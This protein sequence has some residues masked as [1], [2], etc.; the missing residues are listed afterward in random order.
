MATVC[1]DHH[2]LGISRPPYGHASSA[3]KCQRLNEVCPNN[4][5]RRAGNWASTILPVL[6]Q[7]VG[8]CFGFFLSKFALFVRH[9]F[10][11]HKCP[12]TLQIQFYVLLPCSQFFISNF[13]S[14]TAKLRL[15]K[16]ERQS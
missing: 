11:Y 6:L 7:P 16:G 1:A 2:S 10:L 4:P 3:N 5:V 12:P 13:T 15:T 14:A 8:E 9:G